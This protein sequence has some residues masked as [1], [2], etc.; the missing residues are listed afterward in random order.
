MFKKPKLSKHQHSAEVMSQDLPTMHLQIQEIKDLVIRNRKIDEENHKLLREKIENQNIVISK[1][2]AEQSVLLKSIVKESNAT[3]STFMKK[4]PITSEE[5]LREIDLLINDENKDEII[6]VIRHLLG[7]KG[8]I[9]SMPLIIEPSLLL[10]Y[11]YSGL[12]KKKPLRQFANFMLTLQSATGDGVNFENNIRTAIK[13]VKNRHF[14]NAY[15]LKLKN[16]TT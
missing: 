2:L 8:I 4:F 15:L 5:G 14:K 12:N 7:K 9:K 13:N 11:N 10:Q 16:K 3:I 6:A 1:L